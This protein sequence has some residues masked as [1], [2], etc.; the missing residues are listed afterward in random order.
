MPLALLCLLLVDD[1][2]GA[3][4]AKDVV[5]RTHAYTPPAALNVETNLVESTLVIRNSRGV[6]QRGFEASDFQVF[7]NAKQQRILSFVETNLA[8]HNP[9]ATVLFF[10]DIHTNSLPLSQGLAAARQFVASSA[11]GRISVAT[12]SGAVDTGFTADRAQLRTALGRIHSH[13]N[14]P[15]PRLPICPRIAPKFSRGVATDSSAVTTLALGEAVQKVA[16]EPGQRAIVLLSTGFAPPGGDMLEPVLS[17]AMRSNTAIHSLEVKG[18]VAERG[19]AS[20]GS[21]ATLREAMQ[22]TA[23]WEPLDTL[24]RRTGGHFFHDTNDLAGAIRSAAAPGVSYQLT[25]NPGPRDGSFHTLKV[26][27]QNKS[28]NSLQF[29]SGYFSPSGEIT[30]RSHLD[31]ALFSTEPIQEFASRLRVS[32]G[33]LADGAIPISIEVSIDVNRFPFKTEGARH[34]QQI[35]F[36]MMLLDERGGFV[37]GKEAVMDLAIGD[38][39]LALLEKNG[40]IAVATL[41]APPGVYQARAVVREGIE[42]KISTASAPVD[43]RTK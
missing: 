1:T 27:F 20:P 17:A 40:L 34:H 41:N 4:Q 28:D 15:L 19:T 11:G 39:R 7:D 32:S 2:L 37:T 21:R 24:A 33:R 43:L 3:T 23:S 29:R 12:S 9:A 8:S 35:I 22:E 42:G 5:I 13:A 10:D 25:Y 31:V 6:P 26:A 36:L 18:L 14:V 30:P 38:E 16:A